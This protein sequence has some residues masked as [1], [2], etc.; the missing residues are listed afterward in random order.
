MRASKAVI[1]EKVS[2]V[3]AVWGVTGC[4]RGCV[5]TTYTLRYPEMLWVRVEGMGE[6]WEKAT[7]EARIVPG[8]RGDRGDGERDG[9]AVEDGGGRVPVG[10]GGR[11][12]GGDRRGGAGWWGRV[13]S[14]RSW[15]VVYTKG[16]RELA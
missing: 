15:E 7:V 3:A 2:A 4:H 11:D 6:H 14:D 13:M 10:Y 8:S 16:R 1:E 5:L 12:S 9:V